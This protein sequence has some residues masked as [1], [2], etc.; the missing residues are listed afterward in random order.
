MTNAPDWTRLKEI[1][2]EVERHKRE[3]TWTREVFEQLFDQADEA[4]NGHDEFTEFLILD[5]DP[6][7][8]GVTDGAAV[9]N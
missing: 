1:G 9:A 8:L 3:G 2:A 7:W 4:A 5:A 6:S